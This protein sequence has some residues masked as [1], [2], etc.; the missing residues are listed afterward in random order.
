[1]RSL[2]IAAVVLACAPAFAQAPA[3]DWDKE[4]AALLEKAVSDN[5]FVSLPA[6]D[7]IVE[8]GRPCVP[9]LRAALKDDKPQKRF[10]AA[11]LLGKIHDPAAVPDLVPLLDDLK[12]ERTGEPVA[13][14][15]ARALGRLAD[16]SVGDALIAHLDSTDINVR[17]ECAR[18]VGLL[19]VAKAEAKL[20]EILKKNEVAESFT[21]GLMPAAAC[22]SLGRLRS[23]VA[24]TEVIGMLDKMALEPRSGWTL[25]QFAIGAL[26]RIAGESKGVAQ[27]VEKE[28]T[29]KAWK[30]WWTK[31]APPK[32]PEEPPKVPETPK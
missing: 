4:T 27:G 11:E 24:L 14:A 23:E 25:D 18:A 9:A 17:Y 31:K 16:A 8:V 32:T 6:Y 10:F 22:E 1:M 15:A 21:G 20:L 12:E 2:M 3:I 5:P 30:E 19:R 7:E 26:E 28:A 29:V 13:A